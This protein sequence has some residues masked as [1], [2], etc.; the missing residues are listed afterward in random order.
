M[1]AISG[2]EL[3]IIVVLNPRQD[4]IQPEWTAVCEMAMQWRM[5]GWNVVSAYGFRVV[6]RASVAGGP[7]SPALLS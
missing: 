5:D 2:D 1:D 3:S 7:C 6:E 4:D